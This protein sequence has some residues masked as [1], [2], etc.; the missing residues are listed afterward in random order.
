MFHDESLDKEQ[1]KCM[2]PIVSYLLKKLAPKT[3]DREQVKCSLLLSLTFSKKLAPKTLEL[4]QAKCTLLAIHHQCVLFLKYTTYTGAAGFEPKI[5]NF[6][7]I[8]RQR[9]CTEFLPKMPPWLSL[10]SETSKILTPSDEI[11]QR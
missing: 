5:T 10:T 6:D 1:V 4:E 8:S 3:L 11:Y 9:R 7:N 2:H